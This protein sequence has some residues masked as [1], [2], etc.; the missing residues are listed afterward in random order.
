MFG[1]RELENISDLTDDMNN[2]KDVKIE[3]VQALETKFNESVNKINELVDSISK[4]INKN[5]VKKTSELL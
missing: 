4:N 3:Y 1:V 2:D 5:I